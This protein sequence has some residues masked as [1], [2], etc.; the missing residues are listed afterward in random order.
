MLSFTTLTFSRKAVILRPLVDGSSSQSYLLAIRI[1]FL[2]PTHFRF[3]PNEV[4]I[5]GKGP[6]G[7]SFQ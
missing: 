5:E 4:V 1:Q 7:V 2:A 3:A 6:A